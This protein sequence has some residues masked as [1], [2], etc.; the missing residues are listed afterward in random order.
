M[1]LMKDKHKKLRE[2]ILYIVRKLPGVDETT[3]KKILYY[4]DFMAYAK[5][6]ESI[7]GEVYWKEPK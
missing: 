1:Y 6:G 3:L 4:S 2:L 7:T 5:T